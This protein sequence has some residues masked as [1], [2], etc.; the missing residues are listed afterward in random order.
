MPFGQND[1]ETYRNPIA[2]PSGDQQHEADAEKP[3]VM[4]TFSAFLSHRIL[5]PAFVGLATV[6]NE[7]QNAVGWGWQGGE[8]ILSHPSDEQV[9]VPIGRFEDAS[10][11]PGGD[12]SGRPPRHLLQGFA[13]GIEGLHEDEPAEHEAMVAFPNAGHALKIGGDESGQIRE[14]D[15]HGQDH[16]RTSGTTA[17]TF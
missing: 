4:L 7:I 2:I 6:A 10:K 11:A 12:G 8:K 1:A 3:G 15:H 17:Q 16:P 14:G 13:S 5:R 9:D